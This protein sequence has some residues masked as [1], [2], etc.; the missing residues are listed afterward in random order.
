MAPVFL[1][2]L[3]G[4]LPLRAGLTFD[5]TFDSSVTSLSNAAQWESAF[6]Y[7]EDQ[8]SNLFSNS[9]T[10][11]ITLDASQGTSILGQ[12]STGL[13]GYYTYQQIKSALTA[14]ATSADDAI[15]VA[16]LPATNPAASPDAAD[17]VVTTAQGKALGLIT[18]T[19][20]ATDGIITIGNGYNYT[21]DPNNRAVSGDFDFIGIAEHEL[22]EVM[23]RIGILG[24]SFGGP[25]AYGILDL[26]GY[27]AP[28]T[29]DLTPTS[30][31][32]F[33]INGGATN[34]FNYN[35]P[36]DGGDSKDWASGQNDSYNAFTS[37]GVENNISATDI[38]EMDV[39]GYTLAAPEP[40]SFVLML[41]AGLIGAG[42][43]R[44]A[45]RAC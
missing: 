31:A 35:D 8:Y 15:A 3:L 45:R 44:R 38:E 26:F 10:L 20:P 21:F 43:I 2:A 5:T 41:S 6:T 27:T 30:G 24:E 25:A 16:N 1:A 14:S 23:G 39:I 36:S 7:A 32:Y 40:G 4:A 33:S 34:L 17:F 42:L 29:L 13:A 28:N 18:A 12:S 11:N 9:V 37:P 22:S 19:D